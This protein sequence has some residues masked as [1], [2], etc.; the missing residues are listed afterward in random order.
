LLEECGE[1]KIKKIQNG[2]LL[3][4]SV[5]SMPKMSLAEY[6]KKSKP[7]NPPQ[8]DTLLPLPPDSCKLHRTYGI[9]CAF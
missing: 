7:T 3:G 2:A 9:I 4:T 6:P 5:K 8:S 1:I